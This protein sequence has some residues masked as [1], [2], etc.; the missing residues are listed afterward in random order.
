MQLSALKSHASLLAAPEW[1]PG[2]PPELT[3]LKTH[4]MQATVTATVQ[5][6]PDVF[7]ESLESFK[8]W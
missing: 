2:C 7:T 1:I 4:L 3:F 5:S 8:L 6:T